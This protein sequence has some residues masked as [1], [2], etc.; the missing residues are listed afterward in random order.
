MKARVIRE[1]YVIRYHHAIFGARPDQTHPDM[2]AHP[3]SDG[4]YVVEEFA[5]MRSAY[6]AAHRVIGSTLTEPKYLEGRSMAPGGADVLR[7]AEIEPCTIQDEGELVE[8]GI[9]PPVRTI[10]HVITGKEHI[11]GI[12]H[13]ASAS[14]SRYHPNNGWAVPA[15]VDVF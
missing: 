12:P 1:Y 4:R 7:V 5:D 14:L 13:F 9:L 6:I 2:V 11:A 15:E 8:F 3:L 10:T